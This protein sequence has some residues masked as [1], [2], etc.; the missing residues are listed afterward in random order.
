MPMMT[1]MIILTSKGPSVVIFVTFV[2]FES[3]RLAMLRKC[4]E[5]KV[6]SWVNSSCDFSY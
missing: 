1:A 6:N 2:K 4:I 3:G 5:V